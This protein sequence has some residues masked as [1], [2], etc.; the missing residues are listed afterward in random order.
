MKF[1]FDPSKSHSNKEK[2]GIDFIEGPALWNS[3][4]IELNSK[5]PSEARRLVIGKIEATFWTG[6]ITHRDEAIRIISIRRSRDE[7]KEKFRK[8]Y[9]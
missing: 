1:E 7:E 2:H 9:R 6:I 3:P 5:N 4:N 8:Y